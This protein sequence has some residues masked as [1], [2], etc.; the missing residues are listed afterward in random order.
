MIDPDNLQ[1][2]E[3]NIGDP[4]HEEGGKW[5]F[6]DESWVDY[7][8]PYPSKEFAER[9]LGCYLAYLETGEMPKEFVEE[10]VG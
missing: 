8:G 10:I 3:S 6:Y 5:Y 4:V 7:Y 9:M 1:L 2:V